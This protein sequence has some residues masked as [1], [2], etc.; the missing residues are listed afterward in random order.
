MPKIM[1]TDGSKVRVRI[2]GQRFNYWT[3]EDLKDGDR[4]VI[5]DRQGDLVDFKRNDGRLYQGLAVE[6][7]EPIQEDTVKYKYAFD[8]E[9][10]GRNTVQTDGLVIVNQP[11]KVYVSVIA[12]GY[13]EAIDTALGV[14]PDFSKMSFDW[15]LEVTSIEVQA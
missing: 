15:Q 12:T 1:P 8:A 5:I 9:L 2:G 10:R 4:G 6:R 14:L 7:F 11:P 3:P 13:E